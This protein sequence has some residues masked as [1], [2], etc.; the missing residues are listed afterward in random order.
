MAQIAAHADKMRKDKERK[1][2]RMT[3]HVVRIQYQRDIDGLWKIFGFFP[4]TSAEHYD[5]DCPDSDNEDIRP[6]NEMYASSKCLSRFQ[7]VDALPDFPLDLEMEILLAEICSWLVDLK[8]D[9]RDQG[10]F[11]FTDADLSIL[12]KNDYFWID[13]FLRLNKHL[14]FKDCSTAI[15][16][17]CA[18]ADSTPIIGKYFSTLRFIIISKELYMHASLAS[19]YQE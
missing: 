11:P 19:K 3:L 7:D 1:R 13:E 12:Y 15:I 4:D 10:F 6:Y 17:A 2:S 5:L 18:R 8:N 16:N 9:R 14:L